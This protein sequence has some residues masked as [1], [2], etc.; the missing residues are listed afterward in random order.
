MDKETAISVLKQIPDYGI[1]ML[2]IVCP[3]VAAAY[4]TAGFKKSASET[5]FIQKLLRVL[6]DQDSDFNDWLKIAEKFVKEHK[7]DVPYNLQLRWHD[8]ML[9]LLEV[10]TR[11]SGGAHIANEIGVNF[12]ALAVEQ[13][14]NGKIEKKINIRRENVLITQ[15]ETPILL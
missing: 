13:L 9:F 7:I 10:N 8:N 3:P 1:D 14:V 4:R 15:I 2:S 12:L 6:L 11:M 5:I